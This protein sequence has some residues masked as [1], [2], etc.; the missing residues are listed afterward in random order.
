MGN[1]KH[2]IA[3]QNIAPSSTVFTDS[4]TRPNDCGLEQSSHVVYHQKNQSIDLHLARTKKHARS[5][6]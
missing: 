3:S 2:H 1:I 4:K 5:V 6:L